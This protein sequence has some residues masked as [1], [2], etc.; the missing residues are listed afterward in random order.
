MH[1]SFG[2]AFTKQTRF[3]SVRVRSINLKI[4]LPFLTFR[5]TRLLKRNGEAG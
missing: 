1:T 2:G 5:P 3:E 4:F